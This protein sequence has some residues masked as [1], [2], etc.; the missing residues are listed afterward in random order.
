MSYFFH[1]RAGWNRFF[2]LW[3]VFREKK[4]PSPQQMPES[5]IAPRDIPPPIM[6]LPENKC[7]LRPVSDSASQDEHPGIEVPASEE[8]RGLPRAVKRDVSMDKSPLDQLG[9][10]LNSSL[11]SAEKSDGPKQCAEVRDTYQVLFCVIFSGLTCLS[12]IRG[13][14]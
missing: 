9:H 1:V 5:T 3:G 14:V 7:S 8:L 6:S 2:F 12:L 11:S 4:E 13:V 10:G